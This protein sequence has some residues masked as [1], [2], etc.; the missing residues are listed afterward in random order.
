MEPYKYILN[1]L[2]FKVL[3]LTKWRYYY[4]ENVKI[5]KKGLKMQLNYG[6]ENVNMNRY[7]VLTFYNYY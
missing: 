3:L 5:N 4:H 6:V 7:V 2:S 1:H